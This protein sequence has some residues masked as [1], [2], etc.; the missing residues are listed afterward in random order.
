[1]ACGMVCQPWLAH[2]AGRPVRELV[3]WSN[4]STVLPDQPE[5][6]DARGEHANGPEDRKS[7]LVLPKVA[8]KRYCSRNTSGYVI[9]SQCPSE[10]TFRNERD[11]FHRGRFRYEKEKHSNQPASSSSCAKLIYVLDHVW[12]KLGADS[13]PTRICRIYKNKVN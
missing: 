7:K 1:M 13:R 12:K 9:S 4:Q 5:E 10:Q 6:S 11:C 3:W 2:G 8:P